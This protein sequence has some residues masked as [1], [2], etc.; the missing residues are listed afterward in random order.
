[1]VAHDPLQGSGQAAF[2]H[3]ALTS[4]SDAK[5]L[6][7]KRMIDSRRR[8]PTVSQPPHAVPGDP[9]ILAAPRQ[10]ALPEPR[11]LRPEQEERRIV[12]RDTEVS[13]M[14]AD[15]RAQPLA[16]VGDGFVHA[17]AEFG[18]HL[19]QLG[20]QPLAYRLP[21]HRKLSALSRLAADVGKAEESEGF[22]LPFT[23]PLAVGGCKAAELHQPGLVGMQ[24]QCELAQALG[25]LFPKS[26]G[27]CLVLK[28]EHEVSRP[29][30]SHPQALAEPYMNVAAHTAPITQPSA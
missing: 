6:Q 8:E 20:L 11:H 26:F 13:H 2:P 30:E 18:F 4:G 23:A 25:Q 15:Y 28:P 27:I 7:R 14:T 12:Q 10:G 16:H 19:A 9:A 22:G 3:P 17:P 1:M 24:F 29:G 5:A 21:Q